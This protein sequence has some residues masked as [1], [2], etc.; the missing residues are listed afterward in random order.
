MSKS[1][2]SK[3]VA[4][5]RLNLCGSASPKKTMSG[6]TNS[7]PDLFTPQ[8]VPAVHVRL[9]VVHVGGVSSE[10]VR[11]VEIP[12]AATIL[13]AGIP[14]AAS[15]ESMFCVKHRASSPS[16]AAAG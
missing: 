3:S 2:S 16:R 4:A 11:G 7:S 12:C 5:S 13:S 9:D 6:L 8:H 1:Q 15:S 14:A 10:T